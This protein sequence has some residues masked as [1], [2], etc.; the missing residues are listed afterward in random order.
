MYLCGPNYFFHLFI[1]SFDGR[2]GMPGF[3]GDD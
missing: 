2:A 1:H 3:V